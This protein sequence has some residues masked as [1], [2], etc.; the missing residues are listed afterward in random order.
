MT[1]PPGKFFAVKV[2]KQGESTEIQG[3]TG[4]GRGFVIVRYL[5]RCWGAT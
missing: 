4:N 1:V 2:P 5:R 3:I